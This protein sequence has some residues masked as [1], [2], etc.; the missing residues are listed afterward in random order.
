MSKPEDLL[1]DREELEC[2]AGIESTLCRV[3]QGSEA[4]LDLAERKRLY[5]EA[6][7]NEKRYYER[8]RMKAEK[9]QPGL[10]RKRMASTKSKLQR[11]IEKERQPY[12]A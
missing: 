7:D 2:K 9:P 5:E 3:W 8:E 6:C 1:S 12:K 10:K 4:N 11:Q